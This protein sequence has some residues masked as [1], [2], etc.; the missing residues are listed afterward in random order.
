ME[1]MDPCLLSCAE[2]TRRMRWPVIKLHA[3]RIRL[4]LQEYEREASA[5]NSPAEEMQ[6]VVASI[7]QDEVFARL[8]FGC[9][10]FL[11]F[12]AS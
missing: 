9:T 7:F 11:R 2:K 10:V 12:P 4:G 6:L 1:T 3:G 8:C 5:I